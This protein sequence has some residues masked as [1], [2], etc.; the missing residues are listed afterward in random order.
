M[1]RPTCVGALLLVLPLQKI[2][3]GT[4]LLHRTV[5]FTTLPPLPKALFLKF[6]KQFRLSDYDANILIDEKEIALYFEKLCKLTINYKSAAN[7]INGSIKSY[8][9]E[10]VTTIV[11][12][13]ISPERLAELIALIDE[14]KISNSVATSKVFPAMIDSKLSAKEIATKNNW[15][16]ESDSNALNE[17]VDAAIAKYPKKVIEYKNGKKGLIGL[18]MGEV[19]KLSKGKADPKICNQLLRDKLDN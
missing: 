2:T 14:G 13:S 3:F 4:S 16:Q 7:F 10:N 11:N 17:V 6:T 12:F 1:T 15:I 9:N 8:L 5:M 19:M 18:F